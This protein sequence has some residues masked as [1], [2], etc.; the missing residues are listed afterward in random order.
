[1]LE[2][3]FN[4]VAGKFAKL[5]FFTEHIGTTPSVCTLGKKIFKLPSN[6]SKNIYSDIIYL[7]KVSNGNICTVC[8]ICSK[9][10]I[11]T[12]ILFYCLYFNLW[13]NVTQY[14]VLFPLLTLSAGWVL[15]KRSQ[16]RCSIKKVFLQILQNSQDR[17]TPASESLFNKVAS[18]SL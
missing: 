12:S 1:M 18:L 3:L 8:E 15:R 5:S 17:K 11:K 10:T 9:L 4:R 6:S 16:R 14:F 2:S 13:T 7:F